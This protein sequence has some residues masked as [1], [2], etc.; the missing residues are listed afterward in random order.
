MAWHTGSFLKTHFDAN[1]DY[2]QDRHYSAVLYLNDPNDDDPDGDEFDKERTSRNRN[3]FQGGDLVFSFPRNK[4]NDDEESSQQQKTTTQSCS[5]SNVVCF[6]DVRIRPKAGRLVCFPSTER[7]LHRVD[8]VTYGTRYTLTLWFTRNQTAME[9]LDSLQQR[10]PWVISNT[11]SLDDETMWLERILPVSS[12][13]GDGGTMEQPWETPKQAEQLFQETM[14]RAQLQW[15]DVTK[16]GHRH[17]LNHWMQPP[18]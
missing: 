7:Y 14:V 15:D 4:S 13:H 10:L 17:K 5:P 11:T 3:G 8:E 16:S 1:R 2:L 18:M 9:T 12:Q 6:T